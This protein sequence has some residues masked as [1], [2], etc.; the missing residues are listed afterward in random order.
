MPDFMHLVDIGL[1]LHA[2]GNAI[3]ALVFD[4]VY[5]PTKATNEE[6]RQELWSRIGSQ[7]SR[8]QTPSQLSNLEL[9]M[10]CDTAAPHQHYPCLSTRCKA[11]E[12]RFCHNK[13]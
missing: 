4:P 3:F 8:R 6:R 9:S 12:T 2:F 11:A 1:A 5:F 13:I 10:F 7:Y